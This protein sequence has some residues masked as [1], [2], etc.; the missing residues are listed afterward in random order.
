M[1]YS[2]IKYFVFIILFSLG[3]ISCSDDIE[4]TST[5]LVQ[6]FSNG[7]NGGNNNGPNGGN[8]GPNGGNNNGPN[9]ANNNGPNGGNNNGPNN[10]VQ[11]NQAVSVITEWTELFLELDRNIQGMRPTSTARA[12]AY[13]HLT[14]YEAAVPG[15][16]GYISNSANLSGLNIDV[17]ADA[18]LNYPLAVNEAYALALS[19]FIV[20]PPNG[21]RRRINN[22]KQNIENQFDGNNDNDNESIEWAEY[23]ASQVI[24]YSQTDAAAEQQIHDPQPASYVPPTGLG[25]W[26]FSAEPERALF[27]Y[28]G[29]VRTFTISSAETSSVAPPIAYSES[30]SSEYYQQMLDVYVQNNNARENDGEALWIAEFWSDDVESITFGPPTRQFAIA[31]QLIDQMDMSFAEALHLN[32]KLGFSLNDAA[33]STWADK[34]EYMVMRPSVYIQDLIDPDYQTN[35]FRLIPWPNPSFPG[36]PSGHSAFASA[37]AGVF[38][39]FFGSSIQFTDRSHEGRSEFRSTPRQFSSFEEMAAENGYSRVPLGV[40]IEMDCTEGLRLG[41][42]VADAVNSYNVKMDNI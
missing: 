32:L 20:N 38:I 41:Y 25:Y 12:L 22:L 34:Y 28:W 1:V 3:I 11:N 33:V 37:A 15:L 27:P 26:T 24:A 10:G 16:E 31:N 23:V 14:A 39:D 18:D 29:Q 35:L 2:Q 6:N 19:H 21:M 9:G 17:P 4:D 36:Y 8:N 13:I 7:Q 40:H 30:P 5:D 42:E